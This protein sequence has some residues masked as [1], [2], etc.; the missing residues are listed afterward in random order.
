MAD[1]ETLRLAADDF[2]AG[3]NYW[4][5]ELRIAAIWG[6][7]SV[8]LADRTEDTGISRRGIYRSAAELAARAAFRAVPGL[9]EDGK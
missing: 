8:L 2:A 7:R 4:H 6:K 3:R 9:R 1:A 5:D